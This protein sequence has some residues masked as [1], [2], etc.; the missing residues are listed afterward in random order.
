M[1]NPSR[2]CGAYVDDDENWI[3]VS[4]TESTYGARVLFADL[5]DQ[6]DYANLEFKTLYPNFSRNRA[7][8]LNGKFYLLTDFQSVKSPTRRR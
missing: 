5:R 8:S 4:Q 7:S 3:F 1:E 2:N 6:T